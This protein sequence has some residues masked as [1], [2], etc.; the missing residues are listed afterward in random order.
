MLRS[1]KTLALAGALSLALVAA[2]IF[3]SHQAQAAGAGSRH[4]A[5]SMG[6]LQFGASQQLGQKVWSAYYDAHKDLYIGT[7]VSDKTQASAFHV[8][9]APALAKAGAGALSP[10]YFVKGRAAAGQIAVFGSEPPDPAYSPLW[11]EV[12]VQ[13]KAGA[14]AVVLT[15]DN[16]ILALAK[17]GKLTTHTTS[18]VFNAPI[19]KVG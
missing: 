12:I 13:W 11:Q 7:D 16:Q 2:G 18:I 5:A 19:I 15:S 10:M 9:Y 14:K 3:G 17:K 8:N 6:G 1:R 4:A